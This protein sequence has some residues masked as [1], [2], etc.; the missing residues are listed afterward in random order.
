MDEAESDVLAYMRLPAG[1][2]LT[3]ATDPGVADAYLTRRGL[4]AR[5]PVIRGHRSCPYYDDN[6][7]LIGRY[8]ALVVPIVGPDGSLQSA[9]RIYDADIAPRKKTLPAVYTING[10]AV[11]LYD[12]EEELGLGEGIENSLAA[13]QLFSLPVW[14]ALTANG[15]KT[16]QPPAGLRRLHV[17]SDNDANYVG[18]AAAYALARRVNRDGLAVEVHLPPNAD[19]DWL[20]VL[21]QQV[22]RR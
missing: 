19:T 9:H 21:N 7:R 2:S 16:F 5:S 18:Q 4:T 15:I 14:S 22:R 1:A 20:D 11:R 17:F 12:A 8:P 6:Y 10:A 13:H 3:E